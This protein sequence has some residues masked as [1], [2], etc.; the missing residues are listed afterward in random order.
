MYVAGCKVPQHKSGSG[1]G[2]TKNRVRP[3]PDR[4]QQCI[5]TSKR[6]KQAE[7]NQDTN[8][9]NMDGRHTIQL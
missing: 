2:Q 7:L 6:G 4:K 3:V 8:G 5:R 9:R 1:D